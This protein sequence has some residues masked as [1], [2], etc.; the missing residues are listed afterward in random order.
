MTHS[1]KSLRSTQIGILLAAVLLAATVPARADDYA[2]CVDAAVAKHKR[3]HAG[4]VALELPPGA[5]PAEEPRKRCLL[6]ADAAYQESRLLCERK[7]N[8]PVPRGR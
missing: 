1:A 7:L 2:N 3:A 8:G 4:C 6:R 5:N